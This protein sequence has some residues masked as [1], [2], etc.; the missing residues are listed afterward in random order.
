VRFLRRHPVLVVVLLGV[1]IVV[2]PVLATGAAV[3]RAAHTDEA[4]RIDH[5]DLIAVLGA[6]EYAGRPTPVFQGRLEHAVELYQHHFADRILTLGGKQ[7]GDL[8]TEAAAGANWLVDH[9][10]PASAVAAASVGNDTLQSI[11]AAVGYMRAHDLRTVFLVSDPWHN[12]RIRRMA[13]DLG[14]SAYVSATW[15]SAARSHETRLDGYVRE[16]FAYLDYRFFGK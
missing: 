5:V 6:A 15:T 4:R 7:P 16:T 2:G 14:A 12:L 8:T 9:G 10:I 11:R 13:R 1:L 3:W